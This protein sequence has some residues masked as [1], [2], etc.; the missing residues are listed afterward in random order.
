MLEEGIVMAECKTKALYLHLFHKGAN[1]MCPK[2]LLV[3]VCMLLS[4][5]IGVA[6]AAVQDGILVAHCFDDLIDDS[7]NGHVAVLGGNANIS[8]GL[9]HLD[10][11]GDYADIGPTTFGAVNPLVNAA[12]DFTIAVAYACTST[13]PDDG[14]SMIVSIGPPTCLPEE[15]TGDMSLGAT[16]DGQYLDHWWTGA[17]GA[18]SSGVGYSNG[19]VHMLILTYQASSDTY[20]FYHQTGSGGVSHGTGSLNWS[21]QWNPAYNYT[22][23]LG[24]ARNSQ[25]RAEEPAEFFPDMDGE[26]DFFAMWD[27]VLTI[28]EMEDV[29]NIC[30][31]P[32]TNPPTPDPA[33][34]SS[35]PAALGPY[36]I[37]MTA[38]TATDPSGVRYFFEETTGHTGGSDSSWQTS[39]IY[40]DF[41]L[42]PS[43][44][45]T[46]KTRS[47]D[48]SINNNET[49]WSDN[50]GSGD[51]A[52]TSSR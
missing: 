28:A 40:T 38:T 42:S 26:I 35:P 30:G 29:T 5:T 45:Y 52:L 2:N 1:S 47:R 27:R 15:G 6:H 11:D 34:W 12:S 19:S 39:Q 51:L 31:P 13:A 4:F 32:D 20:I 33:T 17:I 46:Y 14:S 9:L 3:V 10:G 23:R 24:A 25:L 16:N 7:G 37:D 43:T 22:P 21:G 8:G 48:Q 36:S 49:A 50:A 44:Q 41:A 18:G